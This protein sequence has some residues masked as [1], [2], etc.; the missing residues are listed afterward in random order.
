MESIAA[1]FNENADKADANA[2]LF[3]AYDNNFTYYANLLRQAVFNANNAVLK[4]SREYDKYMGMGST[5][6]GIAIHD[7]T[8]SM[9]NVGDSRLYLIRSGAIEQISRDHTLAEDQI[10]RGIMT[11][12]EVRESQLRHVLSSVIGVDGNIRIHMDEMTIMPGDVFLLCTDGLTAG[13]EDHDILEAV[14]EEEPGPETLDRMVAK[15]NSRGGPDNVTVALAVF[16]E[17]PKNVHE[18]KIS[19]FLTRALGGH[20]KGPQDE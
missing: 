15:V 5:V 16:S 10:E 9:I 1:F 7:R 2:G 11:R 17:E 12:E 14:L 18:S 4:K 13:M 19:S 20:R 8:L 3:A 6:A